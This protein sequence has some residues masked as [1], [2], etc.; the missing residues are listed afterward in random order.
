MRDTISETTKNKD[1]RIMQINERI[2]A[3]R[4]DKD[5]TQEEIAKALGTTRQQIY[6]YEAGAQEMTLSKLR[7]LCLYYHVSADYNLGL[8][9]GLDWPR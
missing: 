7:T 1:G 2:R 4:I 6:K 9:R 5:I 3:T 8:P